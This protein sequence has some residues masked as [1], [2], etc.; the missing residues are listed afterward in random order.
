MTQVQKLLLCSYHTHNGLQSKDPFSPWTLQQKLQNR[1]CRGYQNL[2]DSFYYILGID[3][4]MGPALK[5]DI[6]V[7]WC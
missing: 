2:S 6:E 1:V 7:R 4:P 5:L 3:L